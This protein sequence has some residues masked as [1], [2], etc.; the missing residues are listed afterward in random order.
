MPKKSNTPSNAAELRL[1]AE[2][3]LKERHAHPVP[4]RTEADTK[5]LLHE[6]QVH[7]IELEMQ[8]TELQDAR[9]KVETLLETYTDLYDFAPVGYFSI[10]EQGVILEVNLTGAALLGIERSRLINQRMQ[11][12]IDPPSRAAFLAFLKKIF[13]VPGKQICEMPLLNERGIPFW[14]D[15]QAASASSERGKRKWCRIAI[16][17]LT[18]LK[19]E[20]EVR[21]RLEDMAVANRELKLEIVQRLKVEVALKKSEAHYAHLFEQSLQMQEQLRHLSRQLLLTQEEERKRISRELHDEIVQTLVGINV[22]LASL[23]MKAPVNLKNLRKKITRTQR[24]V[25][26]SVEIVHRFAREL[27]PT[28]LDDLGLVPALQAF[29]KDFTNRTKI[30][31]HFTAFAGVEQLTGTQ[32][33]VL[34]RV[35]QSALANVHKHARANKA[36]VSIRKLQ[37]A[38]RLEI[39]D[40]GK[41]FEM[42]RVLFAKRHKRLGLLGSRERVEMVGGKF[43]VESAPG[44]GTTISAEIPIISEVPGT[45][46]S[47]RKTTRLD[48]NSSVRVEQSANGL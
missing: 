19:H 1:C 40:N 27:R 22:H 12:F 5:R 23:T 18:T 10:D 34:Y 26:K 9:N 39:H 36:K 35:A 25:E 7:Q 44:Q 43:G 6:L 11:G 42:E 31:T 20:E 46:K 24:L 45:P 29:I 3:R 2:A 17:D 47:S 16:S 33:T 4:P 30:R 13:A 41:S 14:T 8:N 37:G 28:V 21:R 48:K 38:I 15:L 32:R